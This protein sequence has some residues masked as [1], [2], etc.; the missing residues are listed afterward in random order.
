VVHEVEARPD[1]C[2]L[3]TL[4]LMTQSAKAALPPAG[5]D[6]CFSVHNTNAAPWLMLPEETPW[7]H[8]AP[9]PAAPASIE[10]TEETFAHGND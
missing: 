10:E 7:T 6:A 2:H 8:D 5:T 9:A 4:K 3:V 1:G